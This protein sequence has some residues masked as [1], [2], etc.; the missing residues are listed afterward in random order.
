MSGYAELSVDPRHIHRWSSEAALQSDLCRLDRFGGWVAG[1]VEELHE[2]IIV[3]D[4]VGLIPQTT[5]QT[6]I[7]RERRARIQNLNRRPSGRVGRRGRRSTIRDPDA[8]EPL[9]LG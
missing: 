7:D 3:A 4:R 9:A 8:P 1:A 2:H 5:E 6:P